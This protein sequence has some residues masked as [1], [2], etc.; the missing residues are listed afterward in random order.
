MDTTK[1]KFQKL[2]PVRDTKLS[3][4]A[5]SLDYVFHD[6]DLKNIAIT[7]PYSSG[8]SSMLETYKSANKDKRFIHISLA[9]FESV[10]SPSMD[11][12]DNSQSLEVDKKNVKD[13]AY[14]QRFEADIKSVEGKIL[15]QLIHQIDTKK[16]PQTHFKIKRPLSPKK[17]LGIS[18]M[19]T[20]FIT[21]LIF[22]FN[23]NAWI[24]F[25]NGISS[26]SFKLL[27]SPTTAEWFVIISIGTCALITFWGLF[28]L[29]KLQHN[30][31]LF[32]KLS[33]QGNEV[34]IFEND[35]DSFFDK[36]LNEVL[37]LFQNTKADAIVFEDMDRYNSN[38]IFEKLREINYL[39]NNS[40]NSINNKAKKKLKI[41]QLEIKIKNKLFKKKS[42]N[43]YKTFRFF[44]LLR[45]DIF[46]SKD[47]TKFFDFIIPIVPV[48][49]GANSYDKFIEYFKAGGILNSFD[50]SFLQEL[51]IYI[52]DMRLLKNIYNEYLI[53]HDRIQLTELS[54]NKLLAMITYKNLFPRDFSEL[55][56]GKGFVFCLFINKENFIKAEVAKIEKRIGEI[57]CLLVNAD[58]EQLLDL[59]ELDA[60]FLDE[61]RRIYDVD[62]KESNEFSTR[63]NFIRAMKDNPDKVYSS[64]SYYGTNNGRQRFNIMSEFEKLLTV[65]KYLERKEIVETKTTMKKKQ[66]HDELQQLDNRKKEL[67]SATL[68][69]IIQ[70]NKDMALKVYSATYTDEINITHKY[71]DVKGSLYFPLIKYLV[72]NKHIDENYSDYMSY[73][74]EQGISRIDQIFVRS[75]FDVEAKPFAYTLK[76]AALVASKI[77]PRYYSQPE[78]LNFDLFAFLLQSQNENLHKLLQQLKNNHRID[79]VLEF[80]RIGKE[81][82]EL[83][84]NVNNVWPA[85]WQEISQAND[86]QEEDKNKYL[87]D[88]FYYSPHKDIKRMN[89]DD[90]IT[91]HI[92]TCSS[93]LAISEPKITLITDALDF[94]KVRFGAIDYNVSDKDLFNEIYSRNLY[95]IDQS[96]IFLVLQ[97][98]YQLH[99]NEDFYHRNYSLLLLRPDEP[100]V[101]YISDNMDTYISLV[102]SICSGKIT[103]DQTNALAVINHPD[104][105]QNQKENYI[106]AL[107]TE[108][109]ELKAVD[110][111]RLWPSLLIQHHVPCSKE[112]ILIYYFDSENAFDAAL[113]DF[114]NTSETEKGL[115]YNGVVQSHG[116]DKSLAFYKSLLT[117]N[118]LK[119]EKY[120]ALL[121]TFG[122]SYPKF[123]YEGIDD[124]KMLILINLKIIQM[125]S[126]NLTFIRE[127]YASCR[128]S[129]ILFNIDEYAQNAIN[130]SEG[131]FDFS[132]LKELIKKK[133]ADEN[134][135]RLLSFTNE[136]ISI[137]GINV[138]DAVKKHVLENNYCK[139]DLP[140]LV[141]NYEEESSEIKTVLFTLYIKEIAHI[142]HNCIKTPFSLLVALL[143]SSSILNKSELLTTQLRDLTQEQAI[144]CFRV[145]KMG[146]LLTVFEGKWP[147]IEID[148]TNTLILEIMKSK[149][150]ISSFAEDDN[151][152]GY[153]RIRARR[154]IE[155]QYALPNH[156][157]Q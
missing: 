18:A 130:E 157:L 42:D 154:N 77:S 115:S 82:K 117:N 93:F 133:I 107:V 23:R 116:E 138:S 142:V 57:K 150:W 34:E 146:N 17:M 44:Y 135:I 24:I 126:Y 26:C 137:A 6:D 2:T 81:K 125:N 106:N 21:L 53:Y 145:L 152:P 122:A 156:P 52:D 110:D 66:L 13:K 60:L 79:F 85:I 58:Q 86:I 30:K 102:C 75:V 50:N 67:E 134:M 74:Y 96:M 92:S 27:L 71:E 40:A 20:I 111:S 129:F 54:C 127:K 41:S 89:I 36:H 95:E 131:N 78:V 69:E 91:K 155:S 132:E 46:N 28:N 63:G 49:D 59:D 38:Q 76:D 16:I 37:Y 65:P 83:F 144:E 147:S 4:Y 22:L 80:W 120:T 118:A 151:K 32:R 88:T 31:N 68:S 64:S 48:I 33:I 25:V 15:N 141:S 90:I 3:V 101:G 72:R 143:Q 148:D 56:L 55:Q 109:E 5:D 139:D 12:N 87:V 47:R 62:G 39:L 98:M 94:L 51:S 124:N 9:H 84:H 119:D 29:L 43:N 149:K 97:K 45:D 140:W 103:D 19:F 10:T 114:I 99:Q 153:Y 104:V 61:N 100:I 128:M 8:K 11:F 70:I 7:G 123:T 108:I 136:C 35:D 113:T 14:N 121:S 112:N 105:K 73:F 1:Y